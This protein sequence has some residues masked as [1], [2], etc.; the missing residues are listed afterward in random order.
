MGSVVSHYRLLKEQKKRKRERTRYFDQR[1]KTVVPPTVT[2]ETLF[3]M[4]IM[5]EQSN[6]LRSISLDETCSHELISEGS[7]TEE[8]TM[9]IDSEKR[10]TYV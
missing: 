1:K 8:K 9:S 6:L 10:E 3:W 5:G 2:D 7:C 4:R